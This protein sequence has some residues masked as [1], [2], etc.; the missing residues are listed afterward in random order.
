[1]TIVL[2][3]DLIFSINDIHFPKKVKKILKKCQVG[4][5]NGKKSEKRCRNTFFF[6]FFYGWEVQDGQTAHS[7]A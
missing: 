3:Q 7:Q 6:L 2:W 5:K 1:M 4:R